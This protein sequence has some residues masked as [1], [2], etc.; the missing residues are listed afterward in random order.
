MKC[1]D[2]IVSFSRLGII[3]TK[4]LI[5]EDLAHDFKDSRNHMSVYIDGLVVNVCPAFEAGLHV[6]HDRPIS[7]A[8][9]VVVLVP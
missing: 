4:E 1:D 3:P 8:Y 9:E 7:M 2:H 6:T 5:Y